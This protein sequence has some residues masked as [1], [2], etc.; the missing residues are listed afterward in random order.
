MFNYYLVFL[1]LIGPIETLSASAYQSYSP[2]ASPLHVSALNKT[3]HVNTLLTKMD[4]SRNV[5][6]WVLEAKKVRK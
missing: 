4:H 3:T 6:Q 2:R 5:R 1:F